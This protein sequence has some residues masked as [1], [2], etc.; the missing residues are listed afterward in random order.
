M[1]EFGG[2]DFRWAVNQ[3]EHCLVDGTS[4]CLLRRVVPPRLPGADY[5]CLC[6]HLG[7][8]SA[9]QRPGVTWMDPPW[10]PRWWGMWVTE[11]SI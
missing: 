5:R 6:P 10:L 9:L 2:S 3:A 7:W 8:R 1:R 11:I 4:Q